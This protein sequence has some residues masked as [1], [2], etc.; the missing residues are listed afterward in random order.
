MCSPVNTCGLMRRKEF[1]QRKVFTFNAKV[2]SGVGFGGIPNFS[3]NFL[4][5]Q[6]NI[7]RYII[8]LMIKYDTI[9]RNRIIMFCYLVFE[10]SFSAK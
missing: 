2:T 8:I 3:F 4:A 1:A 5:C 7:Y 6:S 9:S 10:L